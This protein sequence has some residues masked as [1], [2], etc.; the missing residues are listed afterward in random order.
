[1]AATNILRTINGVVPFDDA[2]LG[3]LNETI[4]LSHVDEWLKKKAAR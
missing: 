1:L 4:S 2:L 3:R